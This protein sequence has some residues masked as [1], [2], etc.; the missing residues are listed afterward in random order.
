MHYFWVGSWGEW[1]GHSCLSQV[2][3]LFCASIIT[4]NHGDTL[5]FYTSFTTMILINLV[6]KL[7]RMLL[8]TATETVVTTGSDRIVRT[9]HLTSSTGCLVTA[10]IVKLAHDHSVLCG[11]A[12]LAVD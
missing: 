3:L 4:T 12:F 11:L 2:K 1:F 8:S 9:G 7:L 5:L 10:V 6:T